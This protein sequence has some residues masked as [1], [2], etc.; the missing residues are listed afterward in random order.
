MDYDKIIPDVVKGIKPSG[1]RRFFDIAS[2]LEGVIS[3]GVGE[4]DF[5]TPWAVRKTAIK[6]LEKGKTVYTAN[7]GLIE[8]RQAIS[9]YLNRRFKLEYNPKNEMIVTVGGSEAI[10]LGIR[11]LI[12]PGDE[13]L[14]VEPCFVC[15]GPLVELAGGIPVSIETK[16]EDNFKLTAKAL[17]EKI[18]EKTKVLIL[19]YPNNPTGAVMKRED[20]EPIAEVLRETN[21]IVISDEIYCEL[22]Y[23][24]EHTSI[25]ALDG[26][27][28]RTLLINGFSKSYAMTGWRLGYVA[29]P[30]PIIS[31][32]LKLHQYAIM[33]SPT[34]SQYAAITALNECDD[35]VKKMAAEYDL[36]RKLCVDGF[37][38]MGLSCFNPEGA[39]YV[40]PS[41][42]STGLSSEEFC[43]RL[44]N[45]YK[46]AVVPGNAFG[47]SG[48]GYVRVSYAY[49]IKHIIE[50][51]KRIEMF[52][53]SLKK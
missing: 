17:K 32:M 30:A 51:L 35:E 44:V 52:L 26:M 10:D 8:L 50:A 22:T 49:S 20:L 27:R 25:A 4:P 14:I 53:D 1:I 47:K 45:E 48:E 40:F 9:A 2:E 7:S 24:F 33:C 42:K 18:T 23:G 21:I 16:E 13:V 41:I 11:A 31:Q 34:V 28:E 39:F 15:Y 36:R 38:R 5:P 43:T 37:N 12:Q 19:P 6:T 3:L 46:V 29:G